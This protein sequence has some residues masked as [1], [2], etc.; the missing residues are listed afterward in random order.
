MSLSKAGGDA[1]RWT[2]RETVVEVVAVERREVWREIRSRV[3]MEEKDTPN[4][5]VWG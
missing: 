4:I 2:V 5:R 3:W 1:L